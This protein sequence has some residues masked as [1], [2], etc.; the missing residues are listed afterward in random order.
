[1]DIVREA[2]AVHGSGHLNVGHDNADGR[3]RFQQVKCFA[4]IA[5]LLHPAACILEQIHQNHSEHRLIIN[6]ENLLSADRMGSFFHS[7]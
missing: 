4:G 2:Q 3:M 7:R 5:R 6:D 1:M